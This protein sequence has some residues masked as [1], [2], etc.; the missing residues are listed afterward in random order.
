MFEL[1]LDVRDFQRQAR[2]L[3]AAQ[4]QVPFALALA[5]NKAAENTRDLLVQTW[6]QHVKVRNSGF[7]R[8]ALRREFATKHDLRI[9]I[10][11][12]SGKPFIKRLDAGGVHQARGSNL[13]I[14]VEAN[15]KIGARGVRKSQ[16]PRSLPNAFV[17]GNAIYQRVK[18]GKKQAIKLMYILKPSVQVSKH[19]PFSEDFAISMLN[20][21]RTS[22]PA[23]MA[24]AMKSRRA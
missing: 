18:R 4:D 17:K 22:F 6:P 19:I 1:K 23:A 20:E 2:T 24:R 15:V 16:M 21:T 7:I 3:Q 14:P 5:L 9:V 13:A 10:F 11:D 12:Q 8:Y